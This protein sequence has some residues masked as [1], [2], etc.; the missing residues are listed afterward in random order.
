MTKGTAGLTPD[1]TPRKLSSSPAPRNWGLP[2][3]SNEGHAG[4]FFSDPFV[5]QAG[6]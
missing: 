3:G 5:D 2:F 4:G 6:W 1:D